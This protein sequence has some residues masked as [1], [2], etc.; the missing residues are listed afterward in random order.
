VLASIPATTRKRHV[1]TIAFVAHVDTSPDCSGKDVKP[2]VHH[3]YDGKPI[4]FPDNHGLVL[5]PSG[6]PEL[7]AAVG[8]DVVTASGKTLLGSDDKSGVAVIMTLAEKL[9]KNRKLRHGPVRICFTPDE[10]IGRGVDKAR[11]A[12][13][14]EPTSPIRSTAALQEK[15][16]GKHFRQTLLK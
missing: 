4:R 3:R 6:S 2:R 13:P 1:P 15:Y 5:D 14:W 16:P 11:P 7:A 8:K 10:E 9:L 12:K